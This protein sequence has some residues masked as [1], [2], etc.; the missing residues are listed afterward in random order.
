MQGRQRREVPPSSL[1]RLVPEHVASRALLALAR[2]TDTV[3]HEMGRLSAAL[4]FPA[5]SVIAFGSFARGQARH[6]SDLEV[7]VAR[8]SGVDEDDERWG[9]SLELWRRDL[10]RL[11]GNPVEVLDV[12]VDE[13]TTKFLR[14]QPAVDRH[15]ARRPGGARPEP[16]AAPDRKGGV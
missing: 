4:P 16:R 11:T 14:P 13:A 2:S 1:F 10:R 12:S 15:P 9:E 5:G 7:V 3:L 6:N 8:P